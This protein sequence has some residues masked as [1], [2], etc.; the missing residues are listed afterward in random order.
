MKYK[1]THP[2]CRKPFA[3]ISMKTK[4]SDLDI[5]DVIL[6]LDCPMRKKF[7]FSL[8]LRVTRNCATCGYLG[9]GMEVS[10]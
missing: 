10:K 1:C 6:H 5:E 4:F 3:C 9:A 8:G 2:K 7:I